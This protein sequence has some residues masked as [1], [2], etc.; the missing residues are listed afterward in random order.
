M[1]STKKQIESNAIVLRKSIIALS[2]IGLIMVAAPVTAANVC[3][4]LDTS[5]CNKSSSCGWVEGYQRKDGRSVKSFCRTN[6]RAK[7]PLSR[8]KASSGAKISSR[9][10][11]SPVAITSVSKKVTKVRTA[12]SGN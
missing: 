9:A 7:A 2:L 6:S 8:A 10:K 11:A 4:G 1:I 3:K 5:A 12:K